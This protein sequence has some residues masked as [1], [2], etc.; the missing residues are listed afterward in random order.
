MLY[1][2]TDLR[3]ER[4]SSQIGRMLTRL[5]PEASSSEERSFPFGDMHATVRLFDAA[6]VLHF[7]TGHNRG[8]VVSLAPEV[9][10]ELDTF[11][12]D[13]LRQRTSI[14]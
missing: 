11:V 1:L 4:L 9:A 12:G 10:R 5:R 3:E 2:R 8:T 7:P 13:C 6:I 14:A